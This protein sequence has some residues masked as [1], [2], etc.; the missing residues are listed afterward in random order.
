MSNLVSAASLRSRRAFTLIELL[1]VIAIIAILAAILFPVFAQAREKARGASCLS[2][3]KQL[4]TGMLMYVQDYDETLPYWNWQLSA[5]SYCDHGQ[6]QCGRMES[7]WVNAIYPYVK[8]GGVYGCPSDKAT[9]TM[10]DMGKNSF[11]WAA[12][13]TDDELVQVGVVRELL[14]AKISY[15]MTEALHFGELDPV[16]QGPKSHAV[17]LA[18]L[19]KPA[20][21]LGIA[22]VAAFTGGSVY[23]GNDEWQRLPDPSNPND[24]AHNCIIYRVAYANQYGASD[25]DLNIYNYTNPCNL[26]KSGWDSYARHTGGSNIGFCD[27]HVKFM[28][29]SAITNDLFFGT[30][31]N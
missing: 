29:A 15:G 22:D 27:G 12:G 14:K 23:D 19:N 16:N 28:R 30:Q 2:N 18:A 3:I 20:Q 11:D 9:L 10:A 7:F 6:P 4:T 8:N 25:P 17:A 21:T 26:T 31:A 1:V 13:S 24:P 5:D